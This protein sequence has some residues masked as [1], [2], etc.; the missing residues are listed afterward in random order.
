MAGDTME[1]GGRSGR[2]A[3]GILRDREAWVRGSAF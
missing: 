2:S 3:E 1:A